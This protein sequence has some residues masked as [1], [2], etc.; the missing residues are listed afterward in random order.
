MAVPDVGDVI[1]FTLEAEHDNSEI[2]NNVFQFKV[3][4]GSFIN[5]TQWI[6]TLLELADEI[7]DIL[8]GLATAYTV[9]KRLR[10][11]NI[12]TMDP[13]LHVELAADVPGTVAG[14]CLPAGVAMLA[15]FRTDR[16]KTNLRKY[17]GPIGETLNDVD[18]QWSISALVGGVAMTVL[19]LDT[20]STVF[21]NF[22]Y[23]FFDKVLDTWHIPQSA[24]VPAEPAYQRRR[25]RGVGI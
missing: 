14:D 1:E 2:I 11:R 3:V 15:V 9:W 19:L 8:D 16:P 21:A 13:T 7:L 5:E 25:R 22:E 20:I 23:G 12:T 24:Y 10:A 18:G 4:G 17:M 6:I